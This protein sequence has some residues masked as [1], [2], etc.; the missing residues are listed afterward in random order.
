MTSTDRRSLGE[1]LP[2]SPVGAAGAVASLVMA[3]AAAQPL[4]FVFESGSRGVWAVRAGALTTWAVALSLRGVLGRGRGQTALASLGA[5]LAV[6]FGVVLPRPASGAWQQMLLSVV[7]GLPQVLSTALPIST[8]HTVIGALVVIVWLSTLAVSFVCLDRASALGAVV[9]AVVALGGGIAIVGGAV[10]R[11]DVLLVRPAI[12]ITAAFAL[13]SFVRTLA[14]VEEGGARRVL[15]RLVTGVVLVAVGWFAGGFLTAALPFA[16]STPQNVRFEPDAVQ[17]SLPE[18]VST[19]RG[20][21][22]DGDLQG[23]V[24][25]LSGSGLAGWHGFLTVASFPVADYRDG[26]RW[27]TRQRFTPSGGIRPVADLGGSGDDAWRMRIVL[28][29]DRALEGWLPFPTTTVAVDGLRVSSNRQ[30]L[31]PTSP[32]DCE[33]GCSYVARTTP[34]RTL[35]MLLAEG[36]E[37]GPGFLPWRPNLADGDRSPGRQICDVIRVRLSR[38]TP[39]ETLDCEEPRDPSVAFVEDLRSYVRG[40]RRIAEIDGAGPQLA[41]T[42][43]LQ[44]VLELVGAPRETNPSGDPSQFATAF[45]LL[46]Q[47]FGMDARFVVGFRLCPPPEEDTPV[48]CFEG[49]VAA[50]DG[51]QA[52]AWVE[53]NLPGF[54]WVIVDPSPRRLAEEERELA[55]GAAARERET[56]RDAPERID[57]RPDPSEVPRRLVPVPASNPWRVPALLATGILLAPLPAAVTRR[58]R[59][60]RRRRGD[61]RAVAIG[62]LHEFIDGLYDAG[63][64]DLEGCSASELEALATKR[65]DVTELHHLVS[66]A[67]LAVFSSEDISAE[68]ADRAWTLAVGSTR[69]LR[70]SAKR[71]RRVRSLLVPAPSAL[72]VPVGRSVRR[73]RADD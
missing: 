10:D 16:A 70:K 71:R 46:A 40:G 13:L 48:P 62:A 21:R 56:D 25:T 37:I 6:S 31:V 47:H 29:E 30:G 69:R 8:A 50:V 72:T 28:A 12:A 14:V 63:E 67:N 15:S 2:V 55:A 3:L 58:R 68:Q 33:P 53:V 59:R 27:V 43:Q 11:L 39:P 66:T 52:W 44:P 23:P 1:R 60:A 5:A 9:A 19:L 26:Q 65:A 32:S 57:A 34:I 41:V 7:D 4:T 61:Q 49:N 38:R 35:D 20:L 42:D 17:Q 54:G 64:T 36:A 18:P 24:A 73:S 22:I 51:S 45:A